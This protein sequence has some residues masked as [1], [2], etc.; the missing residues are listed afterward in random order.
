MKKQTEV[1]TLIGIVTIAVVALIILS[2]VIMYQSLVI[3]KIMSLLGT[4]SMTTASH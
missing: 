1:S 2:I 4:A 3:E